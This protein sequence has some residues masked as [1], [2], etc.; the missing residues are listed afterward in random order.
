M[1][2]THSIFCLSL[3]LFSLTLCQAQ[4]NFET[5]KNDPVKAKIYTLKNGLKVYLSVYKDAP[6][7]QTFIAAKT[8]SKNDPADATGLAHYLEHMLFKGTSK[9]ASLDWNKEKVLL[10]QISDLYEE[11]RTASDAES[12]KIYQKIDSLSSLAAQYVA[13]NEYD[14]M[15][16]SL[17]AK[18][19]NAYTWVDQTVYVNDI[20]SNGLEKWLKLEAERFNELVLRLFH[21]ELEAVYEEFNIGQNNVYRKVNKAMNEALYPNHPYGTQ[22]TIGKGEHL[23]RPSMEKIHNY[24]NTYYV[25][26][27]MAIVMA[28][29]FDPE[30]TIQLIE[31]YFGNYKSKEVPKWNRPSLAPIQ[32]QIK[33]ELFS[34]EPASISIA[35][36]LDGI[37]SEDHKIA[38]MIDMLLSNGRVGLMDLNLLQKQKIGER[39]Y[40]YLQGAYDYS[41]F[42]LNGQP[43]TGQTLEEVQD[44]LLQQVALIRKGAFEEWMLA[45]V[46]NNFE[47]SEIKQLEYNY[48]RANKM[49]SAFL[50]DQP[51]KKVVQ[52][53]KEMR[54]ITKQ[55]IV[56]FAQK[57]LKDNQCVVLYK[58][59]GKS[60]DI[61]S[62]AKPEITPVK[63]N[64]KDISAFKN[65]W[66]AMEQTTLQP[67]FLNY[68]EQIARTNLSN[69]ISL[70]YIKNPYN[71]TFSMNYVVNMG[72]LNDEKMPMAVQYLEFL[73]TDKYTA[74]ELK[75][76][77]FK[78]GLDFS[79]Y[80]ADDVVYVSL[81]GL[82]S[83]FEEGVTLFEHLLSNAKADE[84]ALKNMIASVK[85]ERIDERK[86]KG[87]IL[88]NAMMNYAKFG[89]NS[90]LTNRMSNAA[91]DKISSQELIE[92]INQL[93]SYEHS[94]F[95]Y[96]TLA[97]DEVLNVLD[98]HHKVPAKLLPV[99]KAK[100]YE[101]VAT[102]ENKVVFVPYEDMTQAEIMLISKGT[103]A[104]SLEE[105]IDSRLFNEYFGS[106]LSS[107]VFQ[108]IRESKALA[109][110]AYAY[111]SSP[112]KKD[113]PHYFR[114]FI[115]TQADKM[116][117][118]IPAMQEIIENMPIS[119]E[120]IQNAA[121]AI[122]KKMNSER[123]TKSSIYWNY[124]AAAKKGFDRD[125]R[126]DAYD[127]I[128][129]IAEDRDAAV[130]MLKEFQQKTVKGRKYTY[131]V[132][133]DKDKI[134]MD[135]LRT[136]GK[137]EV[138]SVDEIFGDDKVEKP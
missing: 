105:Y 4:I 55:Q 32:Q 2:F 107:I 104:F 30:Q 40:S 134:D 81:S 36:R 129:A 63:V 21:T 18:G 10:Q 38:T 122:L 135:F 56:D 59:E 115:G 79:V 121:K 7:I 48:A 24:F 26:N 12:A 117:Q 118:A 66:D 29:D 11:N 20:P 125:I 101:E 46:I 85:K 83:S 15:V 43:K 70:D 19:T 136:L 34:K 102:E 97:Q 78:L 87:S 98:Q 49:L 33:K 103:E 13:T 39:S 23:K 106:G 51:W 68:Q 72:R 95:Y 69:G 41:S 65:T 37:G 92:R 131:L 100:D 27:N 113:D 1:K 80:S 127:R 44:L 94:I 62:I 109:Y 47:Y 60:N 52:Q 25:P 138:F 133:G 88:Y 124:R 5:V 130:A 119:E 93:T 17:G 77:L 22:T 31:K 89:M 110:S 91:L 123:I 82:E 84:E 67:K 75:I 8:G 74:A 128:A 58:K 96:G 64:R 73:G 9:V 71:Q 45:A 54:N 90:P 137:V 53:Y 99:A 57:H 114:A 16:S 42:M 108:E 61:V 126:K 76:E 116:K 6:R 111:N 86:E 50:Y 120:L 112:S 132:M 28:G 35:W 3:L 14:K